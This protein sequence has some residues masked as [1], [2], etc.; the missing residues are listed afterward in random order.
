MRVRRYKVTQRSVGFYDI[1]RIERKEVE[2]DRVYVSKERD[3]NIK[4]IQIHAHT[5][6]RRTHSVW[7]LRTDSKTSGVQFQVCCSF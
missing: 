6:I 4:A 7:C 5:H 3:R 2:L 1:A